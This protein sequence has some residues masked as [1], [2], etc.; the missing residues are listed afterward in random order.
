MP[1]EIEATTGRLS[2][3]ITLCKYFENRKPHFYLN[4]EKQNSMSA[5]ER[6]LLAKQWLVDQHT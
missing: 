5:H 2:R 1:L 6:Q 3:Y 4:L